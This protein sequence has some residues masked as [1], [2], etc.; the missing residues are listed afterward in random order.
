MHHLENYLGQE[1]AA[2]KSYKRHLSKE[3][4]QK[5]N[6]E[7][8]VRKFVG[9]GWAEIFHKKYLQQHQISFLKDKVD[10]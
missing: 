9:K 2:I 7:D 10:N 4:H 3:E 6:N 1:R 8:A 5:I